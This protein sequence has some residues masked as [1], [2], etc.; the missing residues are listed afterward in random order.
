ML[1]STIS[2]A[3]G[4]STAPSTLPATLSF[5][6]AAGQFRF[7][8]PADWR[9]PAHPL[10][11]QLF[12]AQTPPIGPHGQFAVVCWQL[13]H[14]AP[15]VTD[16]GAMMDLSD[17]LAGYAFNHGGQHVTIQPD[18]LGLPGSADALP[19]RRVRFFTPGPAGTV[20]TLYVVAVKDG[21]AYLFTLAGPAEVF[22]A[23]V[24]AAAPMLQSFQRLQ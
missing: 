22:D 6:S 16:R 3:A 10:P 11:R 18:T 23:A 9:L 17:A 4:P 12:S 24:V 2:L 15:G 20:A 19:G 7:D 14:A 13:D 1:L 21:A 8:Y 5:T